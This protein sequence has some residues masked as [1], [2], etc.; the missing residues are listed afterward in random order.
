M[1]QEH[2]L[3]DGPGQKLPLE[4]SALNQCIV[5]LEAL[6]DMRYLINFMAV[7]GKCN[8]M[9]DWK[10]YC[11]EF[12][13]LCFPLKI[14]RF[15]NDHQ[16][17][18]PLCEKENESTIHLFAQ[19]DVVRALWFWSCWGVKI[20]ELRFENQNQLVEFI[21]HTRPQEFIGWPRTEKLLYFIW[22]FIN[23]SYLENE[24]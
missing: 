12:L 23:G 7:F 2:N 24:K 3:I 11:G 13:L 5:H 17:S 8:S 1:L 10:F 18:C 4:N 22:G 20:E 21:I 16:G 6:R 19:C 14:G 15:S 9:K